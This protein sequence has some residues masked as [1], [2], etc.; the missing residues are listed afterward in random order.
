MQESDVSKRQDIKRFFICGQFEDF[1]NVVVFK[2][3]YGTGSYSKFHTQEVDVL[4]CMS[5]F[6]V[7]IT[8]ASFSVFSCHPRVDCG[9][10]KRNR[11]FADHWLGKSC[12][13]KLFSHIS[14]NFLSEG[15]LFCNVPVNPGFKPV[16]LSHY[17]MDFKRIKSSCGRACP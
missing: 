3:P 2:S 7:S 16:S 11:S 12:S 6:H 8:D 5:G 10:C 17:S 9:D 14:W 1:F 15:M 4:G 13:C